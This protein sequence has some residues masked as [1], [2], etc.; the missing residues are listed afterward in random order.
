[1]NIKYSIALLLL[2][3]AC[4]SNT[5]N[6]KELGTCSNLNGAE[7][8]CSKTLNK[9]SAA[10]Q[11]GAIL[12]GFDLR[13]MNNKDKLTK[14]LDRII[15]IN[16]KNIESGR[17]Y[18]INF[19]GKNFG[20]KSV[21]PG[22]YCLDKVTTYTNFS[23]SLCDM[24]AT[25]PV[26][27]GE[28]K[29]AGYWLAG[30]NYDTNEVKLKV[31]DR[32]TKHINLYENATPYYADFA[33]KL[34]IS[35]YSTTLDSIE[36]YWYTAE[37]TIKTYLFDENGSYYKSND[38]YNQGNLTLGGNW[39]WVDG[40]G[41]ARLKNKYGSFKMVAKKDQLV[42]VFENINGLGTRW[43]AYRN[44][45]RLWDLK[46]NG[47]S[48]VVQYDRSTLDKVATQTNKSIYIEIEY[49]SS[50]STHIPRIGKVVFMR[51]HEQHVVKS[52]ITLEQENEI[53]KTFYKWRF[54]TEAKNQ[55][56]TI[57]M[58]TDGYPA[59]CSSPD[60]QSIIFQLGKKYPIHGMGFK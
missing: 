56:L 34:L 35:P 4:T 10:N 28:I 14:Y 1:M 15:S 41:N 26:N 45:V 54:T 49:N 24:N 46:N 3:S 42:A 55:K 44:P 27:A 43:V 7:N 19:S 11:D 5:S 57:C 52:N 17:S 21:E 59:E 8:D 23:I 20:L 40:V 48:A 29:N 16:L 25:I 6:H 37:E 50:E 60:N 22:V 30:I 13:K 53:L 38:L 12:I 2:V 36:G 47:E 31:F 39:S 51:P 33:E 9:L 58:I 32:N 18:V